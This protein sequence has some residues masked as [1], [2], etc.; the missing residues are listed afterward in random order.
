MENSRFL[1]VSFYCRLSNILSYTNHESGKFQSFHVT[2]QLREG[3]M[4]MLRRGGAE[5]LCVCSGA[6]KNQW[7]Q[8]EGVKSGYRTRGLITWAG[9]ARF[10]EIPAP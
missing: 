10:A 9:L 6:L 5:I 3:G 1:C 8:G 4:K 2:I 7:A